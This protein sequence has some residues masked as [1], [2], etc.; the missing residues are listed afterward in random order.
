M[1]ARRGQ[2]QHA[3]LQTAEAALEDPDGERKPERRIGNDE[4]ERVGN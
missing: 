3:T 2:Q 1:S 4:R